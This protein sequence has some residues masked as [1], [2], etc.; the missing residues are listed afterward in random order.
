MRSPLGLLPSRLNSP[1][2]LSLP[3]SER[4]SIPSTTFVAPTPGLR[5]PQCETF[6]L[7]SLNFPR[8]LLAHSIQVLPQGGS[9]FRNVHLPAPFGAKFVGVRLIRITYEDIKRVGGGIDPSLSV[10]SV[11]LSLQRAE[12]ARPAVGTLPGTL[13]AQH[14]HRLPSNGGGGGFLTGGGDR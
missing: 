4:C 11:P 7:S 3:L 5:F 13:Q 6:R 9:P 12:G 10:D 2:A 8:L 1:T 14:S